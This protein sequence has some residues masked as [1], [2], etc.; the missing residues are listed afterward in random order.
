MNSIEITNAINA[1]GFTEPTA[2]EAAKAKAKYWIRLGVK[3]ALYEAL[4]YTKSD[5]SYAE[6]A[7]VPDDLLI[8]ELRETVHLLSSPH[9]EKFLVSRGWSL[10]NK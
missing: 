4:L 10:R 8:E 5:L 6:Q 2:A 7:E 9:V 1:E 3:A